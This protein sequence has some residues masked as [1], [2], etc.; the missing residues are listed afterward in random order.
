MS[1]PRSPDEAREQFAKI[2][3][4]ESER[5]I[6]KLERRNSEI[7]RA[8]KVSALF[9]HPGWQ[10]WWED[11]TQAEQDLLSNAS[12]LTMK[13]GILEKGAMVEN[14]QGA[15]SL[16]ETI[17]AQARKY[18]ALAKEQPANIAELKSILDNTTKSDA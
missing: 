3:R 11:I 8:G 5:V 17:K 4:D 15:I 13:G 10:I 18:E 6:K 16:I 2:S 9:K 12:L 1:L 14:L 7:E